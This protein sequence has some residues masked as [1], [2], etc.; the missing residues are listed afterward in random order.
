MLKKLAKRIEKELAQA[1][2]Y[3]EQA[4]LVMNDY[5]AT[6]EVFCTL[7]TEELQHAETLLKEGQRLVDGNKLKHM[8]KTEEDETSTEEH[9]CK[10]IWKWEHRTAMNRILEI[11]YKVNQFRTLRS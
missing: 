9:D 8:T 6:A 1:E 10:V 3:C 11:K 2:D 4:Y 5:P 7:C